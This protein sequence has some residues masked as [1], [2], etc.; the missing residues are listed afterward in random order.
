MEDW[1]AVGSNDV[2]GSATLAIGDLVDG[3]PIR[4]WV[5]LEAEGMEE[6]SVG[7][8]ELLVRWMP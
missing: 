7:K 5:W 6:R 8:V 4:R 3:L 1:D 2:I